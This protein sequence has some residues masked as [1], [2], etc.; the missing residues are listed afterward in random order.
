MIGQILLTH[1]Q[2]FDRAQE[3][4]LLYLNNPIYEVETHISVPEHLT[5]CPRP[6]SAEKHWPKTGSILTRALS[7][8]PK[9]PL[10]ITKLVTTLLVG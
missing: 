2:V 8:N 1:G 9:S 6:L 5:N 4:I 7:G 10:G 3:P